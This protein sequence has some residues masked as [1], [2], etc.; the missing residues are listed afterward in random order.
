[1]SIPL[2]TKDA[3]KYV[4]TNPSALEL[5][6]VSELEKGFDAWLDNEKTEAV[7]KALDLA[8]DGIIAHRR[9]RLPDQLPLSRFE[10][11]TNNG[12]VQAYAVVYDL[13]HKPTE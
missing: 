1:M 11:G 8:L 3:R 5:A 6:E 2:T 13:R 7:N 12:L 4:T 10:E 9:S